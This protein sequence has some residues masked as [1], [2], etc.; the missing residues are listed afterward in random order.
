MIH[1]SASQL[2]VSFVFGFCGS[3]ILIYSFSVGHRG[4]PVQRRHSKWMFPDFICI[5][6]QSQA[7]QKL[8]SIMQREPT[9]CWAGRTTTGRQVLFLYCCTEG[10][11]PCAVWLLCLD[12]RATRWCRVEPLVTAMCWRQAAPWWGWGS[13]PLEIQRR[14][15]MRSEYLIQPH[16][17]AE[18][19]IER[20][21]RAEESKIPDLLCRVV[22]REPGVLFCLFS[23]QRGDIDLS[24]YCRSPIFS[25]GFPNW[26]WRLSL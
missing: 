21:E 18:C 7:L 11:C 24:L 9:D 20:R 4:T 6:A 2:Q 17:W 26:S 15:R 10:K 19:P 3:L 5:L 13:C 25:V 22:S 8:V 1:Q 14:C 23:T 16:V 12:V